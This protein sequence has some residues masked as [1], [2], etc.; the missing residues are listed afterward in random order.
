MALLAV[1]TAVAAVL[2]FAFLGSSSLWFDETYTAGVVAAGDLGALWDRV[3][4]T[5]STPPLF[6]AL[7]WAWTQLTD[8]PGQWRTAFAAQNGVEPPPSTVRP[9][10]QLR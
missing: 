1:A 6:Y 8:I 10:H 3:G 4:A 2:R 9:R 7:T 5:E